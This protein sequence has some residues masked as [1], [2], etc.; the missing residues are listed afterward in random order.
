[1]GHTIEGFIV[2]QCYTFA[3]FLAFSYVQSTPALFTSFGFVFTN[4]E[5]MPVF[6]GLMLFTQTFWGPV[7]KLL[8]LLMTV[9]SRRNEFAADAF[10]TSLGK[11]PAL[12]SGL[13]KLSVE[14]LDNLVPDSWYSAYHYSHPPLVERLRAVDV[15]IAQSAAK[16]K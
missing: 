3:L 6:V 10:A 1:L 9:N 12:Q 7:D 15:L 5:T 14:N 16:S 2:S 11:G 13:V 4:T 8:S